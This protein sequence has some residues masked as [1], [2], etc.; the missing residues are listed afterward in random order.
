VSQPYFWKNGRMTLTFPK[1]GLGSPSGLP[2][3]QSLISGVKTPHIEAFF[4]SLESYQIFY[5]E[6]GLAWAIWTSTAQLCQNERSGI[7]LA[8]WLLTTKSRESTRP[9]CVQ[10][11]CDIQLESSGQR[12]QLCFRPHRDWRSAQEVMRP[13]SRG[14]PSCWNFKLVGWM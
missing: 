14:S 6:N 13:Q 7:K 3:F 12:L 11:E 1:W 9:R 2:R 5:V 10:G 8:V 4:I